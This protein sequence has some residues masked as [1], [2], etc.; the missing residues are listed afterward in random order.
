VHSFQSNVGAQLQGS[1]SLANFAIGIEAP[2]DAVESSK[3]AAPDAVNG[4]TTE[5]TEASG[6]QGG[7]GMLFNWDQFNT[8]SR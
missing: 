6:E 1:R 8:A 3:D 2:T 4:E 5:E 7:D